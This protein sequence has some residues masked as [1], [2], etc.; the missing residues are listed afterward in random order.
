MKRK[1]FIMRKILYF[2]SICFLTQLISERAYAQKTVQYEGLT[3]YVDKEEVFEA[4]K[5]QDKQVFLLWG[6]NNCIRCNRVK[7]NLAVPSVKSILDEHYLLWFCDALTYNERS[8]EVSDYLSVLGKSP[9]YPVLSVIDSYDTKTGHGTV[10][11]EQTADALANMLRQY[12]ANDNMAG[13]GGSHDAYVHRNS[14]VVKGAVHEEIKVYAV[15]GSLV[16]RFPK[17][18]YSITRDASSYPGGI[19]IVAGSS[20]W[21]RKVWMK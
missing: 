8:P 20:G 17:T 14:L 19:L 2:I 4:A 10:S 18:A 3:Y 6:S 7:K 1:R 12:V 15:T 5:A 21:A 13:A 9:P 11:G 16:D